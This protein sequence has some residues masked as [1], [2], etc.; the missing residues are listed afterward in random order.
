VR[1]GTAGVVSSL[2]VKRRRAAPGHI[3]SDGG[4]PPWLHPRR[5]APGVQVCR[6]DRAIGDA[7]LLA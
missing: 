7:F 3:T 6:F 1:S 5:C 4:S 2:R